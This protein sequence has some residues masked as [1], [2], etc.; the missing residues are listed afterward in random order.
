MFE[1]YPKSKIRDFVTLIN[2]I[3]VFLNEQASQKIPVWAWKLGLLRSQVS[4]VSE[5]QAEKVPSANV[6]LLTG[7]P[8]RT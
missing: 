8:E 6:L 7:G 1:R 5:G 3:R 2:F 4:T